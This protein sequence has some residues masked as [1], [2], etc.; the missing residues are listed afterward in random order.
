MKASP[1]AVPSTASTFGAQPARTRC[2]RR[3][4]LR[5]RTQRQRDEPAPRPDHLELVAVG[6]DEVGI[7]VEGP[8]GRGIHA[9]SVCIRARLCNRVVGNLEL[10]QHRPRRGTRRDLRVRSGNDDDLV[11]AGLVDDDEREP[12]G[13]IRL[14]NVQLEL[15][16]VDER[17]RRRVVA[18]DATDKSEPLRRAAPQRRLGS[19][20]FRPGSARRTTQS[21][22]PPAAE[23]ARRARQGPD[24]P[25]RRPLAAPPP[26]DRKLRLRASESCSRARGLQAEL[27]KKPRL[28]GL[29]EVGRTEHC[30][31]REVLVAGSPL[32]LA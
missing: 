2:R 27:M 10:T 14:T 22:S 28:A 12:R 6:H 23:A 4:G 1:A 30:A 25:I 16:Q 29:F 8:R 17:F 7:D 9:K 3:A 13:R 24:S 20:P 15:P 11:L 21:A 5:L 18:P 26:R 32:A 31:N 19:L